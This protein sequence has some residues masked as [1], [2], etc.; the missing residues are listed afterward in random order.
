MFAYVHASNIPAMLWLR[1]HT[2]RTLLFFTCVPSHLLTLTHI[3][4]TFLRNYGSPDKKGLTD[5]RHHFCLH[6]KLP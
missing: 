3:R 6:L 2:Q 5:I 4:A 1:F